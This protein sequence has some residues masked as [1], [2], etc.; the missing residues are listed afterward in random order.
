MG[1]KRMSI[2]A[3]VAFAAICAMQ[4]ASAQIMHGYKLSVEQQAYESL[5]NPTVITQSDSEESVSI[6]RTAYFQDGAITE[7]SQVMGFPIGFG[8]KFGNQDVTGFGV[9]G[10]GFLVFTGDE[11]VD[12]DPTD[13]L[14]SF[15][16]SIDE[17]ICGMAIKYI[18]LGPNS[19]IGYTVTGEDGDHVTCNGVCI[20]GPRPN[21]P[22]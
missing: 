7:E 18:D 9:C 20:W 19:S 11:A 12:F 6:A 8:F 13:E 15:T 21:R 1:K 17:N 3:L 2:K 5:T 14:F 4:T 22:K 16:Y 10:N